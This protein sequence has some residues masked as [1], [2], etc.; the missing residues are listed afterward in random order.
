MATTA[1]GP[2]YGLLDNAAIAQQYFDAFR[3]FLQ[4]MDSLIFPSSINTT[5]VVPPTNP[6]PGDQYLLLSTPSGVW[7]GQ[8]NSLAYWNAQNTAS[9]TNTLSPSWLFIAPKPGMMIYDQATALFYLF[10]AGAWTAVSNSITLPLAVNGGGTGATTA[11]VARVNLG[12]ASSGANADITSLSGLNSTGITGLNL[13]ITPSGFIG[14]TSL[15]SAVAN[16]PILVEA[17]GTGPSFKVQTGIQVAGYIQTLQKS[18]STSV[19]PST[20]A[21]TGASASLATGSTDTAGSLSI[22]MGTD[23]TTN[24]QLATVTF[25]TAY[26][27][28]NY[29]VA[30]GNSGQGSPQLPIFIGAKTTT[31]FGIFAAAEAP[32]ASDTYVYDY[33]IVQ[34]AS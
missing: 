30:I 7:T 31:G 25:G 1:F 12:A 29:F 15:E 34:G 14:C 11:Q 32:T 18:G 27:S 17:N 6:N 16:S 24:A 10:A 26:P 13:T 28:A 23:P 2:R 33:V 19:A 20:G 8:Q 5:Q 21:G 4:S 3:A 22:T 9:G